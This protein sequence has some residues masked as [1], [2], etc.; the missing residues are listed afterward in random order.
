MYLK[1]I[2]ASSYVKVNSEGFCLFPEPRDENLKFLLCS[3]A[4]FKEA[5]DKVTGSFRGEIKQAKTTLINP[6]CS[7]GIKFPV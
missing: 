6:S 2:A 7:V 4:S 1:M 5:W 3:D